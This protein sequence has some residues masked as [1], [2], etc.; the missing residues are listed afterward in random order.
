MG[1]IDRYGW[2]TAAVESHDY[3]L[4]AILKVLEERRPRRVLDLGCGNGRI[5]AALAQAG[6]DTV[7]IEPSSDG[8]DAARLSYPELSFVRGSAYDDLASH[9]SFDAIVSAEVIEHLYSPHKMIEACQRA[10]NPGGVLIITTPYHGYLKNLAISI[11]DGWDK[12]FTAL[13]EHMH[14]KFWSKRT[15]TRLLADGGFYR[16]QWK[17]VGRIPALAKSMIAI[18]QKEPS[19][20]NGLEA[21]AG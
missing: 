10:L 2:S 15:L 4:P 13:H 5:T 9:G 20:A 16:P 19:G 17:N 7:G 12:H 18:V 1:T 6:Y 14:I 8:I 21:R 3:L 11:V